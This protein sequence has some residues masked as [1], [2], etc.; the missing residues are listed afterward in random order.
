MTKL[1]P[2]TLFSLIFAVLSH[3][4]SDYD[5][6]EGRYLQKERLFYTIMSIG[7]ILFAGLRTYYNDTGTYRQNY[8]VFISA[9]TDVIHGID[10][11][12]IGENPAFTAV[13]VL[14]KRWGW[15][16]Q[17]LIMIFSIFTIGTHLWFIRKYSCNLWLSVLIFI[18]YAGFTLNMAA[19]KQCTAM[20]FGLLAT[21]RVINKKYVQFVVLVLLGAL[22]HPYALMYLAIPFL[23][24][25][26]WSGK[27]IIM[28]AV[29]AI[30]GFG[31]ERLLGTLLDITDMIG[32]EYNE[33]SFNGQRVNPIRL[34]VTVVPILL[35]LMTAQQ[36]QE[37]EEKDQFL[38]VNLSM[39]NG[40]IM[41]LALFG[42]ANY[43]GRLSHYFLPFQAVAIP[44][45]LKRFDY[46]SRQN[47]TIIASICYMLF[48]VYSAAVAER[49]DYQFRSMSLWNYLKLLFQ[50]E[51]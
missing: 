44:W 49:F 17:N 30:V 9:D 21:D 23:F 8:D 33:S 5:S 16:S 29:F 20:A 40:E 14:M 26:P 3:K 32:E 15:P 42:T 47:V 25:R 50:W 36:V 6:L 31:L 41:F 45:L 39:L 18:T 27:T 35:S 43:F 19:I 22:F 7:M 13:Q 37:T 2:I 51:I 24:F 11:L 4:N 38:L 12:K 1:I 46:K 10:W 48:F 34:A 28:I